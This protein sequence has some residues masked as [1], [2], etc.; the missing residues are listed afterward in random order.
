MPRT[1]RVDVG[2]L[3]GVWS[4]TTSTFSLSAGSVS[5]TTMHV[6]YANSLASGWQNWSWS[7]TMTFNITLIRCI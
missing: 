1:T 3:D 5:T 6:A 4:T 7:T 2:G